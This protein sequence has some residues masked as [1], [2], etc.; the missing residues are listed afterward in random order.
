MPLTPNGYQPKRSVEWLA[1]LRTALEIEFNGGAPLDW[2]GRDSVLGAL[3]AVLA[4]RL[5]ELDGGVI[6]SLAT[7]A[8]PNDAVGQFLDNHLALLGGVRRDATF[9]TAQLITTDASNTTGAGIPAGT[10][11]QSSDLRPTTW[12]SVADAFVPDPITVRAQVRGSVAAAPNTITRIVTSTAGVVAVTNPV[13]AARGLPVESDD[14]ARSR[15][16]ALLAGSGSSTLG[17]IRAR[18]A[19]SVP[20][21]RRVA[22]VENT[23]DITQTIEGITLAPRRIGV[24][25]W[26]PL[27][28]PADF[29]RV[30]Q[31]IYDTKPAGIGVQMLAE[32]G[33]AIDVNG[34]QIDVH[35]A[36]PAVVNVD[37]ALILTYSGTRT[38]AS[39]NADA[40]A[41]TTAYFDGLRP[42]ERVSRLQVIAR[43]ASIPGLLAVN[44]VFNAVLGQDIVLGAA[45]IA[46]LG[47]LTPP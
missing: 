17:A 44:P 35:F 38:Q 18:V 41:R 6:A 37:V 30:A 32:S 20:D 28:V 19:A 7:F 13:S 9:S 12:I 26:P 10:V 45:Q 23:S 5:G 14:E 24:V 29:D 22:V 16:L 25:V 36:F 31:A 27:L 43:L 15:R 46:Q 11:F 34:G 1:E 4:A 8:D 2:P 47:T 40:R 42:G 3:S 21:L 33:T 39:V